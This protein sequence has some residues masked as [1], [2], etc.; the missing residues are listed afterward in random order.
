MARKIIIQLTSTITMGGVEKM[1]LSLGSK[2]ALL[3]RFRTVVCNV[4]GITSPKLLAQF[5][6]GDGLLVENLHSGTRNPFTVLPRLLKLCRQY[7]PAVIHSHQLAT[8]FWGALL[9]RLY[10]APLFC[11]IHSP[12]YFIPKMRILRPLFWR[13]SPRPTLIATSVAVQ[14]GLLQVHPFL[15]RMD[16]EILPNAI[17]PPVIMSASDR[18]QAR[19]RFAKP[20]ERLLGFVGRLSPE[21]NI[22]LLFRSFHQ[23]LRQNQGPPAKLLVAGDGP[24]RSELEA[25]AQTLRLGQKIIF[26]GNHPRMEEVYAALDLLILPSQSEGFPLVC[27]E[28][29]AYGVPVLCSDGMAAKDYLA[30]YVSLVKA[31]DEGDLVRAVKDFLA[32]P[33]IWRKKA[34]LGREFVC[35]EHL[36]PAYAARLEELY[37]SKLEASKK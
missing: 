6:S 10:R 13:L 1:V 34:A 26:L 27:L 18:A 9:S 23:V 30:P 20:D 24:L 12:D 36:M 22:P 32:E 35:R 4:T 25:L 15:S 2:L 14:H 37:L 5:S 21:K 28:A 33:A 17:P 19:Q 16:I 8:F 11:H 31:N 7:P 3:G 29:L